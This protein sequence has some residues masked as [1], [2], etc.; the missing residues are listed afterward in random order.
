MCFISLSIAFVLFISIL[1]IGIVLL[2]KVN[3]GE[4]NNN[5]IAPVV[6]TTTAES[7]SSARNNND[8][9]NADRISSSSDTT[10]TDKATATGALDTAPT[11]ITTA[12]KEDEDDDD[13][14]KDAA[15]TGTTETIPSLSSSSPPRGTTTASR[16][17]SNSN[18][19][20]ASPSSSNNEYNDENDRITTDDSNHPSESPSVIFPFKKPSLF[21]TTREL[22]NDPTSQES[23]QRP[24]WDPTQEP[25]IPKRIRM[26]KDPMQEPTKR[27]RKP[28][29]PR[30]VLS[31]DSWLM[32]FNKTDDSSDKN[33]INTN[34]SSNNVVPPTDTIDDT[35][36]PSLESR[37]T[38]QAAS[39]DLFIENSEDFEEM[40][41]EKAENQLYVQTSG[42]EVDTDASTTTCSDNFTPEQ[43]FGVNA[44]YNFRIDISERGGEGSCNVNG[45][46]VYV[47]EAIDKGCFGDTI[48]AITNVEIT[49]AT[50]APTDSPTVPTVPTDSPST[51]PSEVQNT[52]RAPATKKPNNKMTSKPKKASEIQSASRAPATTKPKKKIKSEPKK[53]SELPSTSRA[54]AT[55]K[56]SRRNQLN[57]K[58]LQMPPQ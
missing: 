44:C 34:Q 14:N 26:P 6:A 41:G 55:K 37:I 2:L 33:K 20:N 4:Q 35:N 25:H 15:S 51:V 42:C 28:K 23:T 18:K 47:V 9:A 32:A 56:P 46:A 36:K 24:K 45:A 50:N 54:P 17:S 13:I 39:K 7:T 30:W 58:A 3:K 53:T 11:T 40:L 21:P 12:D 16:I 49:L 19:S 1:P 57:Y 22:T 5:E 29:E 43:I 8:T 38:G 10:N 31:L 27:I 52:S 48:G